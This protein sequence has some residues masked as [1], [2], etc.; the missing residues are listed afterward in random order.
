[1]QKDLI[2]RLSKG[3]PERET[4]INYIV[5]TNNG[6]G[7]IHKKSISSY[8]GA[9][10]PYYSSQSRIKDGRNMSRDNSLLLASSRLQDNK[11]IGAA[12]PNNFMKKRRTTQSLLANL[13]SF[14]QSKS[15]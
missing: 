7:V 12:A 6:T 3:S 9:R 15:R 2:M 11:K 5:N 14:N 13:K 8:Q 4:T 1:M 10:E